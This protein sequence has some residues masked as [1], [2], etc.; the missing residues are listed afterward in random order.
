[1]S[2]ECVSSA[3]LSRRLKVSPAAVS[4]MIGPEANLTV[5][6]LVKIAD[7]LNVSS[8]SLF[9]GVDSEINLNIEVKVLDFS[10]HPIYITGQVPASSDPRLT[11]V[12]GDTGYQSTIDYPVAA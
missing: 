5:K 4:Q 1:M 2:D 7:A 8:D 11:S 9:S 3:E 6:S 12:D 10:N